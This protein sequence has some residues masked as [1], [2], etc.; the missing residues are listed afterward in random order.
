MTDTKVKW[1]SRWSKRERDILD[2]LSTEG[3]IDR[4]GLQSILKCNPDS[5]RKQLTMMRKNGLIQLHPLSG[6]C[7]YI[8][9]LARFEQ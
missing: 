7:H 5:L 4:R 1:K 6:N 2:L 3:P 9:M 8:Y